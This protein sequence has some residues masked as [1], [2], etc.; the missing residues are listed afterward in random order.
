MAAPAAAGAWRIPIEATLELEPGGPRA[1]LPDYAVPDLKPDARLLPELET[2]L[3]TARP[4]VELILD[5]TAFRQDGASEAQLGRQAGGAEVRSAAIELAGEFGPGLLLS[6]KLG[7][8]YNG[9]D[10]DPEQTWAI[11]DFNVSFA[12]PAAR[13]KVSL[14]QMREDFGYEVVAS[15]NILPQSERQISPFVSPVNFGVKVTHVL[16]RANEMTL[17]YGLFRDSW[18]EGDGKASVSARFTRLLIDAPDA[19]RTLHL[20]VGIR[21]ADSGETTRYRGRPGVAAA[22]EF[23]DTGDFPARAATHLGFEG[24]YADGPL[25]LLGEYVQAWTDAPEAGNPSFHGFY[26]LGSWML[27]GERRGYDRTKGVVKRVVPM[28]RWGAPELVARYVRVD[29]N[30]GA[31]RGGRY[32]R[33]E[34]GVNWWAT[35]R[36]KAGLLW[37]HVWLDR[38][39]ETGRTHS[40]LTRIQWVY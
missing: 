32:D 15:T 5:L 26:V 12:I 35:T 29:L 21:R 3:A 33:I 31:V 16:G 7:I 19:G 6:Y 14:G 1:E 2:P 40:L 36:W 11:S 30:G 10:V 13:T 20:G 8:D 25:L 22:D 34:A 18:G 17:S 27:T 23:V 9:F 38:F 39:G 28:Q 4:G 37:G 24:Q